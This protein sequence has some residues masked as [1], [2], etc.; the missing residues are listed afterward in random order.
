MNRFLVFGLA[1]NDGSRRLGRQPA[2]Y[3]AGDVSPPDTKPCNHSREA[4]K[5]YSCGRQPAD[6]DAKKNKAA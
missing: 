6:Y 2:E 3:E 5:A 4:A 1:R